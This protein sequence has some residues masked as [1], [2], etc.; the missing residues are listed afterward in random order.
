MI[1]IN[2]PKTFYNNL[3]AFQ[4][5]NNTNLNPNF[6]LAYYNKHTNKKVPQWVS[7]LRQSSKLET[8]D[9]TSTQQQKNLA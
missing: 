7:I 1:A 5:Q 8:V 6:N 9:L 4:F 3:K 2:Y